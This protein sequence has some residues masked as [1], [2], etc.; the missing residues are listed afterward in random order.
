MSTNIYSSRNLTSKKPKNKKMQQKNKQEEFSEKYLH[1]MDSNPN[2][3]KLMSRFIND[4][5]SQMPSV[6][7]SYIYHNSL[8]KSKLNPNYSLTSKNFISYI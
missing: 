6:T 4:P 5:L 8:A 3:S 1:L 7:E 2:L